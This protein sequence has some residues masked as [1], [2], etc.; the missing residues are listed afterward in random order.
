MVKVRIDVRT[1]VGQEWFDTPASDLP[2]NELT[3]GTMVTLSDGGKAEIVAINEPG[4]DARSQ[5]I[6]KL[7][8]VLRRW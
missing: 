4:E 2:T 1:D 5:G 8:T 3:V 6:E 7:V